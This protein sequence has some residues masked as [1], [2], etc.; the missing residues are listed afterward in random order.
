M[1]RSKIKHE[2][3]YLYILYDPT[4]VSQRFYVGYSY[5]PQRRLK[6]HINIK[7]ENPFKDKWI[8]KLAERN[9]KPILYVYALF[10]TENLA[11]EAEMKL[12]EFCNIVGIELVNILSGGNKPPRN[13]SLE[14]NKKRGRAGENNA[15]A[16]LTERD[17]IQIRHK[18]SS[19]RYSYKELAEQYN[20]NKGTI[21]NIIV[22]KT[23]KYLL[24]ENYAKS[25]PKQK[26]HEK[27][28]NMQVLTIKQLYNENNYT[29]LVLAQ[30]FGVSRSTIGDIIN[31]RTWRHLLINKDNI[32][33]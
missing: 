31:E 22:G 23:W 19:K 20:V 21:H 1:S 18:H 9:I 12:I 8:N 2:K 32:S 33:F 10:S 13:Y 4:F 26:A 6:E 25:T 27:L 5:N 14:V 16:I 7:G 29:Q 28:N 11:A 15:A 24:P 3:W 30:M 17:V